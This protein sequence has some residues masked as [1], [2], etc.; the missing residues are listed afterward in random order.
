MIWLPMPLL[1]LVALID[2]ATLNIPEAISLL[3][4]MVALVI[5]AQFGDPKVAIFGMAISFGFVW[6]LNEFKLARLGGGDAKL[7]AFVGACV[8]WQISLIVLVVSILLV[9]VYRVVHRE[10]Y[11]KL[12]FAPFIAMAYTGVAVWHSVI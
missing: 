3:G 7:M 9:K 2:E 11:N 6:L 12:A 8:G 5:Q 10:Y 4:T 1:I